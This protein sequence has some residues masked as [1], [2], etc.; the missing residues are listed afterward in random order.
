MDASKDAPKKLTKAQKLKL[1]RENRKPMTGR[2]QK[3]GFD[4][5]KGYVGR[6]F[7]DQ[8]PRINQ[9]HAAGWEFI[10][11]STKQISEHS[12][13]LSTMVRVRVDKNLTG[14]PVFAYLMVIEEE[15]YSD[16]QAKKLENVLETEKQIVKGKE[17]RMK[18]NVDGE[19]VFVKSADLRGQPL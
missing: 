18:D 12:D 15:L 14:E 16:D 11:S 13:D 7:N 10:S 8:G 5:P 3:L 17:P 4:I 1:K 19:L 6:W 9:A 2:V